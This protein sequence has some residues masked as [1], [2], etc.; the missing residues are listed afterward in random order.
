MNITIRYG[1]EVMNKSF[2]STPTISQVLG[3]ASVKAELGFGD[4]VRALINGVE[5]ENASL[6]EDGS[7]IVVETK[8][9]SKARWQVAV[10]F[11]VRIGK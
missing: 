6:V 9:N 1:T 10:S 7:L 3:S 11:R 5:Q 8:A 2:T 4:N